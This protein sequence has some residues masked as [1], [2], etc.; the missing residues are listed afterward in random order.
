MNSLEL[1]YHLDDNSHSMNAVVKN[2]AE[3]ELLKLLFEVAHILDL[4]LDIEFEALKQGG[5][6]DVIKFFKKKKTKKKFEKLLIYFGGIVSGVIINVV[7]DNLNKDKELEELNKVEKKLNIQ[8]LKNDL[9]KDSLTK[10]QETVIIDKIVVNINQTHKVQVFKSR[11]YKTILKESKVYQISSVELDDNYNPTSIEKTIERGKFEKQILETEDLKPVT[12]ED[13][14]IEIVS[15][16]LSH[17]NMKWK[18][19]Y[20]AKVF[21]FDLVDSDFKN[22]VLNRQYSFSNGTSIKCR[23]EITST[24]D[25]NGEELI[26]EAKV[27]EVQEVSDGKETHITKKGRH[28]RE[29]KNQIKIDFKKE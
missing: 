27:F 4:E 20:N 5:I 14:N 29:I 13:A 26:K 21:S 1:H 10:Q 8:K 17:G 12:I 22:S 19:I 25:E 2:K 6:K 23:L 7:A 11:F 28:L 9:E 15:P 18:G 16:V 24:L 3:A